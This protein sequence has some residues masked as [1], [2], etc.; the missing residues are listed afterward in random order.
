MGFR[1]FNVGRI[2]RNKDEEEERKVASKNFTEA[3]RKALR[4]ENQEVGCGGECCRD[5]HTSDD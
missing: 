2:L 1:K 5:L 4:K 3:D